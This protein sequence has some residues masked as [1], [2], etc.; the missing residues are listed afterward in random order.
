M[1]FNNLIAVSVLLGA[2]TFDEAV[3]ALTENQS[4]GNDLRQ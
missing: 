4:Q 2:I 3:N 1:K